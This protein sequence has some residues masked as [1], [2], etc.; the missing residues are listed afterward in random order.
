MDNIKIQK[1]ECKHDINI[2]ITPDVKYHIIMY[3]YDIIYTVHIILYPTQC[4]QY[5]RTST[6]LFLIHQNDTADS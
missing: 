2:F 3:R 4:A 6:T 5:S 1:T